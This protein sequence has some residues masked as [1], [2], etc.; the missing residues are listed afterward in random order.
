MILRYND[1][2]ALLTYHEEEG[3][4]YGDVL[5]L[6][7]GIH[8]SGATIEEAREVLKECV[9]FYIECCQE[10]GEMPEKSF[11]GTIP[12]RIEPELHLKLS[13]EAQKKEVSLNSLIKAA[14]KDILE[15]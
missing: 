2:T 10:R 1:Y 13:L 4:Y 5:G 9:E 7:G 8:F 14:L 11:S 12:L 6:S 3:R 15:A